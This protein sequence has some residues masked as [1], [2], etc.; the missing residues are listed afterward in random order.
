MASAGGAAGPA[1]ARRGV[2]SAR[3]REVT[4]CSRRDVFRSDDA[5]DDDDADDRRHR[6]ARARNAREGAVERRDAGGGEEADA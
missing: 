1:S 6:A 3:P 2:A 4:A 5:D